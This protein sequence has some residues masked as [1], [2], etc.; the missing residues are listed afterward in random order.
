[1]AVVDVSKQAYG[2]NSAALSVDDS[3]EDIAKYD[4]FQVA[5]WYKFVSFLLC[6]Y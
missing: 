2:L 1:M 4:I 5:G 6:S 3:Y